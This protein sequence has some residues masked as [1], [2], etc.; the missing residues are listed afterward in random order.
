MSES[1]NPF[2]S[3][4]SKSK[5]SSDKAS[6]DKPVS[7][8][9]EDKASN[10]P[11]KSGKSNKKL[12]I[13]IVSAVVVL[14]LVVV[15]VIVFINL[16]KVTTKDYS[17]AY[18]ALNNI[19]EKIDDNKGISLSGTSDL[20]ADKYHQMVDKAK[21]QIKSVDK[22]IAELGKMKAI[23]KDKD[24]KEKFGKFKGEFDKYSGKTKEVMDK[25]NE[26]VPIYIAMRKPYNIKASAGTDAYYRERSNSYQQVVSIAKDAKIKGDQE[27]A[28][29]VK[30]L[31]EAA[32][33]Y[34][35][36]YKKV[37]NGEKV[38]YSDFSKSFSKF[39]KANSTVRS[40]V[41][42][43]VSSLRDA[44]YSSS[45]SSLSSYLYKKT[46]KDLKDLKD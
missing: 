36:Y 28:D 14:I 45:F 37:A 35:D 23:E 7:P 12:I 40:S 21:S 10:E 34:A 46:L 29:G 15:G 24:S 26:V 22:A 6:K 27:L 18:D 16:N 9:D 8:F 13:G 1:V 4:A 25:M 2:D 20:T 38:N 3:Q 39:T 17:E 42:K 11:K 33:A 44:N 32:Q 31:A 19:K 5:A 43:M 30:E 41:L